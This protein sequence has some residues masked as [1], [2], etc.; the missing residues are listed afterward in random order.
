LKIGSLSSICVRGQRDAFGLCSDVPSS[1][2]EVLEVDGEARRVAAGL[3][4]KF[5][6]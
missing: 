1:I 3:I 6:R 5:A 4:G 2:D